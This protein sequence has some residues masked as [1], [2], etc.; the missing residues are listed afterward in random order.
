MIKHVVMWKMKESEQLGKMKEKLESL[1]ESVEE[2]ESLE[3]GI[4]FNDSTRA[5]DIVLIVEFSDKDALASYQKDPKHLE[6]ANFVNE[7]TKEVVAV[8]YY[9]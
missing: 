9:C 2:V 8:D 5:Y 6:V 4:N 1:E 3:V 7:V